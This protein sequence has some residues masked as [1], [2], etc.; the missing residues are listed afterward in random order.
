METEGD[1]LR[2]LREALGLT[3]ASLCR[4]TKI[5]TSNWAVL[6]NDQR[7]LTLH[8]ARILHRHYGVTFDYLFL[9]IRSGL[10]VKLNSSMVEVEENRSRG[11][12]SDN[13]KLGGTSLAEARTVGSKKKPRQHRQ[14]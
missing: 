3:Q 11:S 4:E 5:A 8:I 9:G 13:G 10:P 2:L 1:R 7:P 6:E 12:L 14:Q